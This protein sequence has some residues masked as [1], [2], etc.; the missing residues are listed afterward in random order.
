V[1]EHLWTGKP[2]PYEARHPE[3]LSLS[4]PSV[5]RILGLAVFADAW[6]VAS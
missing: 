6:L 2:P 5:A 3:L 4:L 1:G